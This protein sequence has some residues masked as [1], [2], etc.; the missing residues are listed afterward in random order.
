MAKR[1][2]TWGRLKRPIGNCVCKVEPGTRRRSKCKRKRRGGGG[3]RA[4]DAKG[5]FVG[6]G[7]MWKMPQSMIDVAAQGM[8]E[9]E[10]REQ[11]WWE[12]LHGARRRRRFR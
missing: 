4:R 9:H 5:R 7:R 1:K 6:R 3:S 10:E 8:K 11:R 2:C 12:G